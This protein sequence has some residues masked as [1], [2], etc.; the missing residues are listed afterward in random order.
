MAGQRLVL[1]VSG[2][3]FTYAET[4]NIIT[5]QGF[6]PPKLG[7]KQDQWQKHAW[8]EIKEKKRSFK[9]KGARKR[10]RKLQNRNNNKKKKSVWNRMRNSA[11]FRT[12][13]CIALLALFF[14]EGIAEGLR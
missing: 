11:R 5:G 10:D 1:F 2:V 4:L 13:T 14:V 6:Q 12:V 3:K 8:S 7:L 9:L